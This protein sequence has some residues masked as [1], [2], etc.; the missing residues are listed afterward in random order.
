MAAGTPP[1][2]G[3]RGMLSLEQLKTEIDQLK[4][5]LRVTSSPTKSVPLSITDFK[6]DGPNFQLSEPF[7]SHPCGYKLC[8]RAEVTISREDPKTLGFILHACLM[9][10]EFDWELDWPVKAKVTIQIQNQNGDSDHIRRSKTIAWQYKAKGDPLPIPVMT[11]VDV[12]TLKGGG[13]SG[14]RYMVNS[15][16]NVVVKYMSLDV[17]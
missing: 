15:C 17:K 4:R 10:G 5:H 13:V 14:A 7:Y 12:A 2:S 8:L 16:M 11:D 6:L 1:A 3:I 9:E